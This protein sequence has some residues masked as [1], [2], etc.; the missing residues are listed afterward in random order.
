MLPI[1]VI[2]WFGGWVLI[3]GPAFDDFRGR[4]RARREFPRAKVVHLLPGDCRVVPSD[5]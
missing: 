1:L 5:I 4:L 2:L 3:T